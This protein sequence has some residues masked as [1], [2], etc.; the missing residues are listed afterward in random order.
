M[1]ASR[2]L[3]TN[4]LAAAATVLAASSEQAGTPR[5]WLKDQDPGLRWR[6]RPGWN[7][8]ALLGDQLTFLDAGVARTA[9]LAA[10]SNYA[11]PGLYA[12]HVTTQMNAVAVTNTYLCSYNSGSG[13]F[14][15]ARATGAGT[16]GLPFATGAAVTAGR[17]AHPDLGFASTDLT[18]STSYTAGSAS[19][20]GREFI[21]VDLGSALQVQA[22]VVKWHNLGTGGTVRLLGSTVD[23]AAGWRSPD[24]DVPLAGDATIRISYLDGTRR[25]WRLLIDDVS[26]NALGYSE[27]GLAFVGPYDEPSKGFIGDAYQIQDQELS[28]IVT[29]ISGAHKRDARGVAQAFSLT[30]KAIATDRAK[31]EAWAASCPVGVNSLFAF[32]PVGDPTNVV[33]GYFTEGMNRR[34]IGRLLWAVSRLFVGALP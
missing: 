18:G 3:Y 8:H 27:V 13:A 12:A 30:W 25:Y 28:T 29:A 6:S 14:T 11:T 26:S 17:S 33:Y 24:Y 9:Q 19:Y 7:P 10:G 20:K 16:F 31:L 5:R 22:G 2:L 23:T 1:A 34:P 32:D 15:I 21:T 4:R